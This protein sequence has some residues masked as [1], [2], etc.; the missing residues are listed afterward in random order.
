[1]W[2]PWGTNKGSASARA[3]VRTRKV[4]VTTDILAQDNIRMQG[5]RGVTS[6]HEAL[7]SRRENTTAA[8][9]LIQHRGGPVRFVMSPHEA[10][11]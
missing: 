9:D 4:V 10:P 11:R 5:V 1:M 7:T 2:P 3:P 8:C 6:S